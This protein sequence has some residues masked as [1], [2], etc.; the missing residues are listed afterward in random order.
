MVI[1]INLIYL[2]SSILLIVAL[3]MTPWVSITVGSD[4]IALPLTS[5][6]KFSNTL[7]IKSAIVATVGVLNFLSTILL[8]VS[9]F[10]ML[11]STYTERAVSFAKNSLLFTIIWATTT[12]MLFS[13]LAVLHRYS[14]IP[15]Q[16]SC[17]AYPSY[18]YLLISY[19]LL[20]AAR[21]FAPQII[22]RDGTIVPIKMFQPPSKP[23]PTPTPSPQPPVQ[24]SSEESQNIPSNQLPETKQATSAST[25]E[26]ESKGVETV[27]TKQREEKEST[28]GEE[29]KEHEKEVYA[30]VARE[31]LEGE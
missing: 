10:F 11:L 5:L 14:V 4:R 19:A 31:L 2:A 30:K 20:V 24:L 3:V 12:I 8:I 15:F 22:L 23:Q 29:H 25:T 27:E 26:T 9:L 21:G 6:P 13:V 28:S 18:F 7:S 1:R 17:D 16:A